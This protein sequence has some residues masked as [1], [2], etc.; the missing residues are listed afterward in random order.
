MKVASASQAQA[1]RPLTTFLELE[2][3]LPD[4]KKPI[5]V[6]GKVRLKEASGRTSLEFTNPFD[7]DRDAIREFVSSKIKE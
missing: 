1:E 2:F 5:K 6:L 3:N 7:A 4:V